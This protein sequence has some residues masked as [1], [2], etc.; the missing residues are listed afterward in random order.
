MNG[1]LILMEIISPRGMAMK[2]YKHH[3]TDH[4]YNWRTD[5]IEE[6]QAKAVKAF[7]EQ[8]TAYE[9]LRP[10]LPEG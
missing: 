7:M 9:N 3:L 2:L 5:K 8:E 6:T 10:H 1:D 4:Y